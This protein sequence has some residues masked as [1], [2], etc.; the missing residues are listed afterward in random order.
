MG[1]GILR[2]H[3]TTFAA[4]RA[5]KQLVMDMDMDM[6]ACLAS[7]T[8][9]V[10]DRPARPQVFVA[11]SL[12]GI[13]HRLIQERVETK[14]LQFIRNVNTGH[15]YAVPDIVR[16]VGSRHAH[17]QTGWDE[18]WIRLIGDNGYRRDYTSVVLDGKPVVDMPIESPW[19]VVVVKRAALG[20][21]VKLLDGNKVY[22]PGKAR[23]QAVKLIYRHLG[24]SSVTRCAS[25]LT[26]WN[27]AQLVPFTCSHCPFN[28]ETPLAV[29]MRCPCA[30]AAYCSR[31]CQKA[32]WPDHK[33]VCKGV[34]PIR[35]AAQS[36]EGP[37]PMHDNIAFLQYLTHLTDSRDP[38]IRNYWRN[39]LRAVEG[40]LHLHPDGGTNAF[41]WDDLPR[42]VSSTVLWWEEGLAEEGVLPQ[43]RVSF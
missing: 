22:A 4:G 40:M 37:M 13:V 32:A 27:L 20:W 6:E 15:V 10:P 34:A 9:P 2:R 3:A 7:F 36:E 12:C 24:Y 5:G 29:K 1:H 26:W 38:A 17:E 19:S 39:E 23:I 8:S 25:D 14:C 35:N 31:A 18:S 30:C 28:P 42:P 16:K 41:Q 43:A 21:F 11:A 33:R